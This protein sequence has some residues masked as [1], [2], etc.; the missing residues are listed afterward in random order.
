MIKAKLVLISLIL[1][2]LSGSLF[3]NEGDYK[4]NIN[5][6]SAEELADVLTGVGEDRAKAIVEYR[7]SQGPFETMEELTEVKGVGDA[8]LA[9]NASRI[10]L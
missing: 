9:K 5:T 4:V 2:S 6:A 1:F 3:A 8:T 10:E 7:D